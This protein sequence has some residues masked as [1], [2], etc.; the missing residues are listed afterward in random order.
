MLM[1]CSSLRELRKV[2]LL[3]RPMSAWV[4]VSCK[5]FTPSEMGATTV[6]HISTNRKFSPLCCGASCCLKPSPGTCNSPAQGKA[7]LVIPL[8]KFCSSRSHPRTLVA[9]LPLSCSCCCCAPSCLQPKKVSHHGMQP[10]TGVIWLCGV[11]R[12]SLLLKVMVTDPFSFRLSRLD[13]RAFRK[14]SLSWR[15][16]VQPSSTSQVHSQNA[17]HQ[18]RVLGKPLSFQKISNQQRPSQI[19]CQSSTLKNKKQPCRRASS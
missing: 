16:M 15:T 6:K 4:A 13:T 11:H 12:C 5:D 3:A 9:H 18:F 19:L 8:H 14:P 10:S 17:C 7:W 1:K 2:V